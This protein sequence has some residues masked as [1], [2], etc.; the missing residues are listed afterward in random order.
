MRMRKSPCHFLALYRK[1]SRDFVGS[2]CWLSLFF[3]HC[4]I[5][6]LFGFPGSG[7]LKIDFVGELNDKM[8][9]FYR[10]KYTTSAGEIRYAAVTQFEVTWRPPDVF[11]FNCIAQA[12]AWLCCNRVDWEDHVTVVMGPKWSWRWGN[13]SNFNFR[14]KQ[15]WSHLGWG[16]FGQKWNLWSLQYTQRLCTCTDFGPQCVHCVFSQG[17]QL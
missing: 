2:C 5:N 10:S 13:I 17:P 15:V 16:D 3:Q 7:T 14:F 11:L 9:G 1:V 8:K 4:S 6:T 12:T